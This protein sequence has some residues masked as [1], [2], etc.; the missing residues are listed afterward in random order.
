MGT[1][2]YIPAGG[3]GERLRPL[4][5]DIPKPLLPIANRED[6]STERII[7]TTVRIAQSLGSS[8][9]IA[10]AYNAHKIDEYYA[11]SP[12]IEIVHDGAIVHIGGSMIR[13]RKRLFQG[14]PDHI[15]M[16][17]G[18][19]YLEEYAVS[20]MIRA[21]SSTGADLVILGTLQH[22]YHEVYPVHKMGDRYTLARN[23]DQSTCQ[24]SSLGSY[25]INAEWLAK[26]LHQ[27]PSGENG[28]C[29]LTADII[30]GKDQKSP[31]HIIFEPLMQDEKWEDIGTIQRLY[32]HIRYLHPSP[33]RDELNNV[34]LAGGLVNGRATDSV[35]YFGAVDYSY[36]Y[37]NS[38]IA[39]GFSQTCLKQGRV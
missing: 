28:H 22:S 16:L 29:D 24:I 31:P 1:H 38:F 11:D 14:Q 32:D 4:T 13:H 19:H 5:E 25:A 33:N 21:L 36:G 8:L 30:F 15:V 34:N 39:N 6:G 20:R 2:F 35:I 27:A 26:R 17:P 3:R 10:G 9:T 12:E 37:T 23:A 7:D 18:D